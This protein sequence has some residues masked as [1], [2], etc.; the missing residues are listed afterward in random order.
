MARLPSRNASAHAA[1]AGRPARRARAARARAAPAVSFLLAALAL[2]GCFGSGGGADD[3]TFSLAIADTLAGGR[4][5]LR[6]AFLH[7]ADGWIA[8][9]GNS[10]LAFEATGGNVSANGS[11][12]AGDYDGVR[13]LFS[14]LQVGGRSAALAQSGV[15]LVVDLTVPADGQTDLRL[16]VSWPDSLF[17]SASGL[18]FEP[19]L[20]RL[21]VTVDGAETLRLENAAI[22]T[23]GGT[24]PVARI[25][26]FDATGLEVF[27]STFVADSPEDP[28]IANAGEL[29]LS[30]TGSEAL[31]PGSRLA[32]YAWDIDGATVKGPTVRH[33]TPVDGGNMTVRLTVTDSEGNNDAQTVKIAV[34]PG[35]AQRSFNFTGSATSAPLGDGAVTHPFG[36]VDPTL[37][38]GAAARLVH[39]T[40]VLT[41]GASAL[42]VGDLDV[43]LN[44]GAG[45]EVAAAS[46]AGSQERIDEDVD[47]EFAAGDWVVVVTPNQDVES[48][49]TVTV[50]LTWQGVNPG[51]EAFLA[52]Y[53]DGHSHPH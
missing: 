37:L 7:R 23:G 28:V 1:G 20:S 12:P 34:K 29:V 2:S 21:V 52:T 18:A 41:P 48:E 39:V 46:S 17:E 25:R 50:T 13:I 45:A 26:V 42:P 43:A 6:G 38:D 11:V 49:Y 35:L 32:D 51:M 53:E 10:S 9:L 47:G 16:V 5:D 19:V 40:V 33:T 31:L 24:P 30:A 3:G 36:P 4:L 22:D 14:A 15:E 8:A 27:A 44:D